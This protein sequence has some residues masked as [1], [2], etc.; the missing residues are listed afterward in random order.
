ESRI[1]LALCYY[2]QGL[3][4]MGRNTLLRV[5]REV[6]IKDWELRS[7]ALIRLA[8]LERHAG[9]LHDALA[10]LTEAATIME[11]TGP[12][13]VCRCHLELASTY[14]DLAISE[15]AT[16]YFDTAKDYCFRALYE[17]AA[18]GNYRYVGIAE[19]NMGL[20]LLTV[21]SYEKAETQLLRS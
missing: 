21:G 9:R 10:R 6:A 17:F 15:N 12:W 16:H 11:K 13:A 19:N 20:L 2:R 7:L 14:K 1:E 4:D 8:I 5:L 18:L 3:F